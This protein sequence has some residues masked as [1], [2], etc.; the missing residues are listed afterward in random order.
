MRHP[1]SFCGQDFSRKSSCETHELSH[2]SWQFG[3][4]VCRVCTQRFDSKKRLTAH[5]ATR[6]HRRKARTS[7]PLVSILELRQGHLRSSQGSAVYTRLQSIAAA[8]VIT[9]QE[10]TAQPAGAPPTACVEL[11]VPPTAQ[12]PEPN[13]PD[14]NPATLLADLEASGLNLDMELLESPGHPYSG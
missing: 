9:E 10:P 3:K 14:L 11:P 1:C 5:L 13:L 6:T 2:P 4:F 12:M 8:P 7:Q